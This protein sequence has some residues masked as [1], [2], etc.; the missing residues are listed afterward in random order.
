M[1]ILWIIFQVGTNTFILETFLVMIVLKHS[2]QF[3]FHKCCLCLFDRPSLSLDQ[4]MGMSLFDAC[5]VG[6]QKHQSELKCA[7]LWFLFWYWWHRV[8]T[9]FYVKPRTVKQQY[10]AAKNCIVKFTK[11]YCCLLAVILET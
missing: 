5:W 10:S 11:K 9:G 1:Q 2:C 3:F 6:I 7:V 8:F 4:F